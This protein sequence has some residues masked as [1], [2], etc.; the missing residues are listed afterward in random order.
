MGYKIAVVGATGN[1]GREMLN[2]LEER[3]FPADEIFALASSRSVGRELD[4]GDKEIKV[5]DA[6]TF[7]FSK[8]DI[9]LFSAGGTTAKTLAPKAAAA[10]CVVID[11]SS[12]WRME[13]GVPLVVPEVNGAALAG[14]AKKNII[15]NPNCS[16]IQMVMALKPLHDLQPI[17]RVVVAT[18]QSVSGAGRLAMDELFNQTKGIYVNDLP[19]KEQFTKQIAFNVIPHIDVFMDSGDT[20]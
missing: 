17:K 8:V 6:A 4:Y 10:G 9:A 2:T 11:N 7:D 19:V 3:Q 1:V 12:Y 18:Y 15:A 14:Y 13:P 16:T 5:V 20:K